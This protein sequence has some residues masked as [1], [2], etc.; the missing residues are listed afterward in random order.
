MRFVV[1]FYTERLND[2]DLAIEEMQEDRV[3]K[4][5]AAEQLRG[6][7]QISYGS[8][9]EIQAEIDQMRNQLSQARRRNKKF[10]RGK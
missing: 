10:G 5:Q 7:L 1:G 6:S 9:L 4:L 2:L 3:G 8:A